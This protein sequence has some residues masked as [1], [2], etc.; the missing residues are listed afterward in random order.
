MKNIKNFI[1]EKLKINHASKVND[2][3]GLRDLSSTSIPNA[4]QNDMYT[5][6]PGEES[7]HYNKMEAYKKKGSKPIRLLNSIKDR[8]KLV[9]RWYVAIVINWLECAKVF[10]QGI[11]DRGYY[12]ED[13]LDA[14]V[15]KRYN[16][17]L[18][19]SKVPNVKE[20]VE[21]YL[22]EYNVKFD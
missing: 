15:L 10:R 2:T 5:K 4:L 13:E 20:A 19:N 22:Q 14:Y 18:K 8:K 12:N 6:T 1:L 3:S 7:T 21:K 16:S 11:I 17:S 9:Y